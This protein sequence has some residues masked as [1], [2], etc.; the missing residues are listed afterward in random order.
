MSQLPADIPMPNSIQSSAL[1]P[2]PD[3]GVLKVSGEDAARFLQ[4]QATCDVLALVPGAVGCGAFCT[5]KGR[6]LANFRM[7]RGWEAFY[8][9]LARELVEPLQK[10]LQLYVLRAKVQLEN[11]TGLA[12]LH[13]L[14]GPDNAETLVA[15]GFTPSNLS[16]D[17]NELPNL[18]VLKLERGAVT[19]YWLMT[20]ADAGEKPWLAHATLPADAWRLRDIAAGFP[21]ILPATREEFLPQMLNLDRM[22]GTSYT[23]GCY[24]GQEIVTRTHFLGHIKRRMFRMRC[25]GGIDLEPGAAVVETSGAE[26]RTA[27]RI[28]SACRNAEGRWECLAVLGLEFAASGHRHAASAEGPRLSGLPLPYPLE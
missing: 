15:M 13:A 9:F 5:P 19:D 6:V 7:A 21:L 1:C 25:A 26:P 22:G 4:G 23:K 14:P 12:S 16:A 20:P 17:W 11:L 10:R 18:G 28:V 2:L 27:G 24:T 8:L 3:W